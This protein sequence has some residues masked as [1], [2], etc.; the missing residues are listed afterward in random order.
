MKQQVRILGLDDSPF[1]FGDGQSLVVGALVR[2]PNYLEAVM[3]TYVEVDGTDSTDQLAKMISKSRYREQIKA[4]MIDGIAL[5]GFNVV[6]IE[7]LRGETGLPVLTVTRDMPDMAEM[8]SALQKHFDD[9]QRRYA[10]IS[11]SA[12]RRIKTAHKPLYACGVGLDWA[13]FEELVALSTVRGV[14]P[15]PIRIDHLVSSAMV[16]GESYGRS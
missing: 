1:K 11:R 10:L 12:L 8:R 13:E 5:A 14:V 6:D 3:K 2:A 16:R 7:K 4:I 15:G 9:W